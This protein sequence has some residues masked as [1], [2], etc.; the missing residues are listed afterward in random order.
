MFTHLIDFLKRS[1][2]LGDRKETAMSTESPV[3]PVPS[4][5]SAQGALPSSPSPATDDFHRQL[6]TLADAVCELSRSQQ[7]LIDAVSRKAPPPKPKPTT[8]MTI[9]GDPGDGMR[10]SAVIDYTRLSP[11]QQ[12]ALGLRTATP[13]GPRL[14]PARD[15]LSESHGANDAEPASSGAD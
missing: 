13:Q 14:L 15:R 8:T 4:S 7:T 3:P 5:D 2:H 9:T 10:P 1:P 6:L 11:V 12:I